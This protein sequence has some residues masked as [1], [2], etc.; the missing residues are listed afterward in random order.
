L[1]IV[2]HFFPLEK[3]FFKK[4]SKFFARFPK[5]LRHRPIFPRSRA[6]ALAAASSTRSVRRRTT[7]P[8]SASHSAAPPRASGGIYRRSVPRPGPIP[9]RNSEKANT[10][11]YSASSPHPT[12]AGLRRRSAL[13]SS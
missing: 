10:P 3:M 13:T 2:N 11:Q 4:F 12:G 7:E 9:I 6:T 8:N 5:A 1:I